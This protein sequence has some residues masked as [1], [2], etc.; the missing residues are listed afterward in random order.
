MSHAAKKFEKGEIM[1]KMKDI[2]ALIPTPLTD[3][4]KLD[5]TG[6]KRVIDF[7]LEN[8]CSGVGVLAAIGEAYLFERADWAAV[9]KVAVK[10]M[11]GQS[12][13]I[14]GCPAMGTYPAIDLCK[15]AEA[16]GADAILGFNPQ[17]FR[18]YTNAELLRH[19]TA[20]TDA[21][22]IPIAPYSRLE[23]PIPL[24]V[25]T[26]L[27][28]EGRVSYMKY[29]WKN[30]DALQEAAASLGDRLLI[31]CGA[32]TL[33]LKYLLLG[34]QG[35]MTATAAMLPG[36]HAEL[37]SMVRAGNIE[38]ARAYYNEKILPWNDIGFYDMNIWHS[39]HKA[40]LYYMGL[41][42]SP[43]VLEPQGSAAPWQIEEVKWL[44]KNQGKLKR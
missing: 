22:K 18:F 41:I 10:H 26:K 15:E 44:L 32:D 31:F 4:G 40:A 19:Y 39:L 1:K 5:E 2:V 12:P 23:D 24:D 36:E 16:L 42:S 6:L 14:V 38:D 35:V 20:L 25:L 17:G 28:D 30:H 34:C 11:N 13:L 37:L 9:I 21:V 8:G 3:Q 27:V 7:E 29:A 43:K 33:T